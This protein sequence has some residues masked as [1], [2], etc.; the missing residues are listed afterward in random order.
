VKLLITTAPTPTRFVQTWADAKGTMLWA[1]T[2]TPVGLEM[3]IDWRGR[4]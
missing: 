3:F 2:I 4:K 1:G